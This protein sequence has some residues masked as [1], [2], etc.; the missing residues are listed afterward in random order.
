MIIVCGEA[1]IDLVPGGT[2]SSVYQAHA[3]GGP[4]NIAVGLGRL[5]T[6]VALLARLAEDRFGRVLRDHLRASQVDVG[7]IIASAAPTTLAVLNVDAAGVADY[8]FYIDGC[9]DGG[10]RPAE[11]PAQLPA[12]AALHA[13]GSFALAVDSMAETFETLLRRERPHRVITFDP[14]IRPSL[15]RDE[16]VVLARLER[17]LALADVVKVSAE[18]LTW[19][20]PGRPAE[21]VIAEWRERGP[22]IVVVTRGGR[23]A[24][25]VGPAGSVDLQAEPVTVVDTIGAGD[26]FMSGLLAALDRGGHLTRP[27]LAALG[28]RDLAAALAYAQ[29]VAGITVTRAGADPP[30]RED[31]PDTPPAQAR[32]TH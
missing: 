27:G 9:A 5:G 12:G 13:S 3:G 2:G 14:N 17:W 21:A 23:G 19:I 11:L 1:L 4:A 20:A 16:H 8:D 28:S 7:L 30:W 10:W 26:A 18:D 15:I 6:E 24:Y 29:R 31:L 25:A 32:A 22:S